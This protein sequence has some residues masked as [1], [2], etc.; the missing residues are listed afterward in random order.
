MA[1]VA[2]AGLDTWPITFEV[3]ES[4][5][6]ENLEASRTAL[7]QLYDAGFRVVLDD[8]GTGHSSLSRLD[9]IPVRGIK[10]D[11]RLVQRLSADAQARSVLDA[12]VQV[13][14]A[15]RLAVT[16]EGIE[17]AETL[18]IVGDHGVDYAQGYY[19]S[20]PKPAHE[21]VDLLARPWV[22]SDRAAPYPGG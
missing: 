21:L 1:R 12:I 14:S 3:T 2:A 9:E 18:Q 5:L 10:V 13:G 22:G 16:A 17:D 6:M 19:L 15:Y 4:A 7:Q 20:R 8:F 11:K